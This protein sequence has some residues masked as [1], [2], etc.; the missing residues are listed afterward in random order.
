MNAVQTVLRRVSG[1]ILDPMTAKKELRAAIDGLT[2]ADAA[3]ALDFLASR[4]ERD[5]DD[6]GEPEM[7]PLPKGWGETLTGEPMPNVVAA[8]HRARTGH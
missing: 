8:V 4:A 2:E 6:D 7:A 5:G 1:A 3:A